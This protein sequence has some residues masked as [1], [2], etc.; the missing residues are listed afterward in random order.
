MSDADGS[1]ACD[2]GGNGGLYGYSHRISYGT[3]TVLIHSC[4]VG[5]CARGCYCNGSS[6]AVVAP[7]SRSAAR[8]C[9][10][11][12][13]TLADGSVAGDRGGDIGLHGN[14]NGVG[15]GTSAALIARYSVCGG[16][17]RRY[18][19][20]VC[21]CTSVPCARGAAAYCQSCRTASA[22]SLIGCYGSGNI[23]LHRNG[24]GIGFRAIAKLIG[25]YPVLCC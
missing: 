21:C 11:Y 18:G 20:G 5:G 13:L 4:G 14:G 2:S 9:K 16:G 12:A 6:C 7:T 23:R 24:N 17:I 22:D 1:V 25:G 8:R 10:C 15:F 3:I 19:D